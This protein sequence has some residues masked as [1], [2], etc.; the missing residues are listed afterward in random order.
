MVAE[1]ELFDV[2]VVVEQVEDI[3]APFDTAFAVLSYMDYME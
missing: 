3:V 2:V 1:L